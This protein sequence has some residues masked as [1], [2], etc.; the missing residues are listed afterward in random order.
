LDWKDDKTVH[1]IDLMPDTA[2]GR[3][4]ARYEY[5]QQPCGLSVK[6]SAR[7][8]RLSV[9]PIHRVFVEPER[10]RIE[11]LLRYRFRGARAEG[12]LFDM[13]DW[14]FG[15]LTPD[16]LFDFPLSNEADGSELRV[17][18]RPGAAPPTDLELKL[19]AHR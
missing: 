2:A 4:V 3:V 16:L 7:P 10:V 6:V 12:L 18:F 9:E 14:V 17:P 19:E 1:R 15:R 11:S 5:F 13:G 8:S